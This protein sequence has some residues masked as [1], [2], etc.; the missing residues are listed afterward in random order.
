MVF[1]LAVMIPAAALA[2]DGTDPGGT[3]DEAAPGSANVDGNYGYAVVADRSSGDQKETLPDIYGKDGLYV[4][5]RD[6]RKA[7]IDTMGVVVADNQ[8]L[9]AEAEDPGSEVKVQVGRT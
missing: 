7:Y 1:S 9:K 8:G 2:D 5:A 4:G 3:D 6:G